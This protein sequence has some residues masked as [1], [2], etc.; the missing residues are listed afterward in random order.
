M[1]ASASRRGRCWTPGAH[2][3]H[4]P[5]QF[6]ACPRPG[7]RGLR[8]GGAG[9][10]RA[11]VVPGP[12]LRP[13]LPGELHRQHLPRPFAAVACA[14]GGDRRPLAHLHGRR[15]P[16]RDVRCAAGAGLLARAA[17][18]AA[19]PRPRDRVRVRRGGGGAG[20][21][22]AANHGRGP[23]QPGP[24]HDL[25]RR[26]RRGHPARRRPDIRGCPRPGRAPRD[27]PDRG[28]PGR[29]TRPGIPAVRAGGGTARRGASRSPTGS[30]AGSVT[31]TPAARWSQNPPL[32]PAAW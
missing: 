18:A 29:G 17:A 20:G 3:P 6:Y 24:V 15:R 14:R 1:T 21:R 4:G 10:G 28:Q 22:A 19:G 5:G 7:G 26:G 13:G 31:W 30:P 9:C 8:R 12:L 2:P 25:R 11:G 23:V 32:G 27:R 16:D